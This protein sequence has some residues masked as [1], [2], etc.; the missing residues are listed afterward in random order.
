MYF[1]CCS[2]ESGPPKNL[3]GKVL[4]RFGATCPK[5]CAYFCKRARHCRPELLLQANVLLQSD[6]CSMWC[7]YRL[8]MHAV[9]LAS[10]CLCGSWGSNTERRIC[11]GPPGRCTKK[12]C[13]QFVF[14]WRRGAWQNIFWVPAN[15]PT[16]PRW[17]E[18]T[19]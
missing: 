11:R 15:I 2:R 14:P 4:C 8:V 3:R 12:R 7:Y 6:V 5:Q 10:W 16:A 1:L 19:G 17:G 9:V 13:K 18:Y